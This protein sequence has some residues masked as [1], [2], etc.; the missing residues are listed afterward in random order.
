MAYWWAKKLYRI[1]CSCYRIPIITCYF[2][3]ALNRSFIECFYWCKILSCMPTKWQ[4][5]LITIWCN[6]TIT[7]YPIT[8]CKENSSINKSLL[9][10]DNHRLNQ[11]VV[12]S[13]I[14]TILRVKS[15]KIN[16]NI[17]I[18]NIKTLYIRIDSTDFIILLSS[19]ISWYENFAC[20]TLTIELKC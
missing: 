18:W 4:I 7:C 15:S 9:R 6:N 3:F 8:P 11:K 20:F 14:H 12:T 1:T 5:R 19:I 17:F 2:C 13:T 16:K 10:R